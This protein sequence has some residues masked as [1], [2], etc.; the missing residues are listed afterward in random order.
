MHGGKMWEAKIMASH[1]EPMG[2]TTNNH[3]QLLGVGSR[4]RQ[5]MRVIARQRIRCIL[6]A[7]LKPPT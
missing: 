5:N 1:G 7:M 6:Q 3:Q 2:M 4:K